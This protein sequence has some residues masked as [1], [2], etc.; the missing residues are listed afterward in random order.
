MKRK[1]ALL[2]LLVH[3]L[4]SAAWLEGA[5]GN[6]ANGQTRQAPATPEIR[7]GNATPGALIAALEKMADRVIGFYPPDYDNLPTIALEEVTEAEFER[8]Q[9]S[10]RP[11][12]DP[13][14]SRVQHTKTTFTIPTAKA[15]LV[16][17]RDWDNR[18]NE[19][20]VGYYYAEYK[21]YYPD[22]SLYA[23]EVNGSAAIEWGESLLIDAQTS[24]VYS[25]VSIGDGPSGAHFASP[26]NTYLAY[27]DNQLVSSAR[28][29]IGL[30]R[31]GEHPRR[32]QAYASFQSA[33]RLVESLVWISDHAF[34]VKFKIGES[35][36]D[37]EYFKTK[38]LRDRGK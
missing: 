15:R 19:D 36:N 31:I 1:R 28:T 30:I 5:K 16:F 22:L 21:G 26:G 32:Y 34:A 4:F 13:S 11:Q 23:V 24:T 20:Q 7:V 17:N 25:L 35:G 10:Y 14:L 3:L 2:F 33:N 38:D 18:I 29:F 12:L 9:S 6:P 27:Y 8:Y 37:F